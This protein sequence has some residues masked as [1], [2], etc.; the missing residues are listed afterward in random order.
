M[1]PLTLQRHGPVASLTLTR[2][3]V[4][5]AI[6]P[7]M[8]QELTAAFQELSTDPTV[9]VVLLAAEGKSFCAGADLNTMR[10]SADFTYEENM[11]DAAALAG[12]FRAV[13]DC[14]K[15]V[16]GRI[17]GSV[18]GGGMGLV[19][20][21][22]VAI[23]LEAAQFCFTEV[24]LGLLPSVISA[25]VVRKLAPGVARR[26]FV[27]AERFDAR[28]AERFGLIARV[29]PDPEALDAAVDE[30]VRAL[31]KNGPEAI[32]AS[33]RLVDEVAPVDW[34]AV[35]AHAARRIAELRTSPEGQEGIRAFL[36]KRKPAW[37]TEPPHDADE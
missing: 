26:L 28:A 2:P 5:N 32:A 16:V 7:E 34:D 10:A 24:K 35:V 15:P 17:Q 4:H 23:A 3:E 18:Y 22:D 29:A 27:T 33:K 6:N 13:Y 1:P 36:E 12:L 8:V 31:L 37:Q 30:T 21:C 14:P 11:A 25:F 20:A 19:A 9:R